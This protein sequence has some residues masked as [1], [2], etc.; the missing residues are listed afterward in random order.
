VY[1]DDSHLLVCTY[2][3]AMASDF[4]VTWQFLS[5]G[6]IGFLLWIKILAQMC[7]SFKQY[8]SNVLVILHSFVVEPT[9][10]PLRI[11]RITVLFLLKSYQPALACLTTRVTRLGEFLPIWQ[12]L[13]LGCGLK[14]TE[15]E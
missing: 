5:K 10:R 9:S 8:F 12:L 2:V 11:W 15:V 7:L 3:H 13:T 4:S 14:I 6:T 1:W